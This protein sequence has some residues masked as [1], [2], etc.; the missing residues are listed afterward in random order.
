MARRGGKAGVEIGRRDSAASS[1]AIGAGRTK[2][3]SASRILSGANSLSRSKC[4]TWPKRV[5][6]RIGAPGAGDA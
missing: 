4:A 1:T 5:H 2:W 3:F 6:A